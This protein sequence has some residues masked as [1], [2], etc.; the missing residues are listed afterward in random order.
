MLNLLI[1]KGIN[2][3]RCKT[4]DEIL[5]LI[6]FGFKSDRYIVNLDSVDNVRTSRQEIFFNQLKYMKTSQLHVENITTHNTI[7]GEQVN[8]K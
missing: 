8:P 5:V 7:T 2:S 4:V 1:P 3:L 6:K